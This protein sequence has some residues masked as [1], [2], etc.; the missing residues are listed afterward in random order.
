MIGEF[1]NT[2]APQTLE[3]PEPVVGR[4]F[5]FVGLSEVNGNPWASAAE[6]TLVGCTDIFFG[7]KEKAAYRE[8]IA[9]P[10]PTSGIVTIS[11]PPDLNTTYTVF[12]SSG[13]IICQGAVERSLT[14]ITVDLSKY[15]PGIY[16]VR[17]VDKTGTSYTVRVVKH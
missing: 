9:F 16:I 8:L 11:A 13:Q 17:F 7:S 3:L 12:S 14:S 10:V 4:Y 6:F 2:A 1:V 15:S 5:R